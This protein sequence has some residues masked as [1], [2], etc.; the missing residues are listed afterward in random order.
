[1]RSIEDLKLV[2]YDLET[3][4]ADPEGQDPMLAGRGQALIGIFKSR[5]LKRLESSV[6]AFRISVF[7]LM[8]YLLTFRHYIHGN[9]LLEPTDF[10]KLLGT[11]ERDLEDDAQAQEHAEEGDAD[12]EDRSPKPRSRH[13]EIEAN[14]KAAAILKQA[15]RLPAQT[16][17]V[18]RLNDAPD[19]D[20]RPC[21]ASLTW[22][23]P[24]GPR[25][26]RSSSG[27]ARCWRASRRGPRSWSSPPSGTRSGYLYRWVAQGFRICRHAGWSARSGDSWRHGCGQAAEYRAGICP[28]E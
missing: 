17:D 14:P 8:E 18:Q 11:I 24:S 27:S 25:L 4:K 23:T 16:Y 3:Y 26:T 10:W 5:Y 12:E 15:N 6:A 19:T 2:P 7:R 21:E 22:S 9:V 20:L 28:E 13:G 1:M